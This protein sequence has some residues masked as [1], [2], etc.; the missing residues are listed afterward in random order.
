MDV[1]ITAVELSWSKGCN[2][3]VGQSHFIKTVE[4]LSE[5]MVSS[6]PGVQYGLAFCEASGPCL[7]RTE[8]NNPELVKEAVECARK[9]AAGHTFFLVLKNAFPINV[10]N[11]IKN[12]QEV[13]RIFAATA[14]PLQVLVAQTSQGRGIAGVI[15][16]FSPQGEESATDKKARKEMI[17]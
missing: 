8:G 9:V 6:V 14:N 10:L 2:I 4:D 15:D 5:I 16:G 13:C 12:C 17:R 1:T 7:I 3:I 11:Q